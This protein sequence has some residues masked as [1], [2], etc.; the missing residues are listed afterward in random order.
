MYDDTNLVAIDVSR[1]GASDHSWVV[2]GMFMKFPTGSIKHGHDLVRLVAN[3]SDNLGERI[4]MVAV[5]FAGDCI[6]ASVAY[7]FGVHGSA[8]RNLIFLEKVFNAVEEFQAA[9]EILG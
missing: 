4:A 9:L 8:E 3:R 6:G 7:D 2:V 1:L 5:D